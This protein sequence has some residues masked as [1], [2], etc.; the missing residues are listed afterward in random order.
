[1]GTGSADDTA[2]LTT[3]VM[4]NAFLV[5]ILFWAIALTSAC[6]DDAPPRIVRVEEI[7]LRQG[8][9]NDYVGVIGAETKQR[10]ESDL[11]SLRRQSGVDFVIV[12]VDQKGDQTID[13]HAM[14]VIKQ[15]ELDTCCRG[16]I[17]LDI[18]MHDHEWKINV[19][20][21]LWED[22]PDDYLESL[23]PSMQN[24]FTNGDF[25]EG[26]SNFVAAMR[27]KLREREQK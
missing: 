24:S 20:K 27:R 18:S 4:K 7:P 16:A 6:L 1:M 2:E 15:W 19:S 11:A 5:L 8:F 22:L 23:Q 12:L 9:V 21:P 14:D 3:V 17:L 25:S 26:V 10:L 13:Q